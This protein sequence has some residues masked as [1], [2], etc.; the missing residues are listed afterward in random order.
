MFGVFSI[1]DDVFNSLTVSNKTL[2]N[3]KIKGEN[4]FS[5]VFKE[6]S[7]KFRVEMRKFLVLVF[8]NNSRKQGIFDTLNVFKITYTLINDI[9]VM[10][11]DTSLFHCTA[12][13]WRE[14]FTD[15][16]SFNLF[17]AKIYLNS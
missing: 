3:R 12:N 6:A 4:Y 9:R 7:E 8:Y 11:T 15:K 17:E 5:L 1:D 13:S 14:K 2:P 16:G 10:I